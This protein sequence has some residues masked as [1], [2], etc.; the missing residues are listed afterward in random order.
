M[1]I[2]IMQSLKMITISTSI[3]YHAGC[4]VYISAEH[5]IIGSAGTEH[6]GVKSV[7]VLHTPNGNVFHLN[8]RAS[9]ADAVG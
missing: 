5:D 1:Y 4:P 8:F 9:M 7:P 2:I 6:T 3:Y